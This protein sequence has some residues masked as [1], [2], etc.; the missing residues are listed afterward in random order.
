MEDVVGYYLPLLQQGHWDQTVRR[1]SG[2]KGDHHHRKYLALK[3]INLFNVQPLETRFDGI[4]DVLAR[5]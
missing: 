3:E 4:K 1:A 5:F 2:Y